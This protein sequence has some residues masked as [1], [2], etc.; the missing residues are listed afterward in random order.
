MWLPSQLGTSHAEQLKKLGLELDPERLAD[1]MG[2]PLGAVV[3]LGGCSASFVSADGLIITNHHCVTG[4][5]QHNSTPEHNLLEDGFLA[6]SPKAERTVGPTGRVFVTQAFTDVTERVRKGLEELTDDQARYLAVER[7]T[8]E[9]VAECE[10]AKPNVRCEV[11]S[12]FGNGQY[13]LVERLELKDVRL[14]YAPHRGIGDFGGEIDNWRWPR[15]GGDFA[16]YRVYVTKEGKPAPFSET[17]VPYHPSQHLKLATQPLREHDLVFVAGYPGRTSQLQTV[18]ELEEAVQWWYPRRIKQCEEYLAVLGRLSN[19]DRELKIKAAPLDQ[20]FNNSLTYTRGALEGLTKGG[21]SAKKRKQ[22]AD[23]E[24][25]VKGDPARERKYAAAFGKLQTI[26][27]ERARTRDE[28]AALDEVVRMSSLLGA[29]V[30][31]VRMAEE[32]PKPDAERKPDYQ[33]RNWEPIEQAQRSLEK[34]YARKLDKALLTLAAERALALSPNPSV[35][36]ALVGKGAVTH[37]AIAQA[38]DR[39]YAGTSLENTQLRVELLRRATVA[40]L[41]ASRDPLIRMALALR[42]LIKQRED[43]EE[44]RNGALLLWRPLYVA[45]LRERSSSP[46]APDANGTLRVTYGTVRGYAPSPGA[47]VYRPFTVVSEVVGKTTGKEPFDTPERLLAAVKAKKFG[48]YV[49]PALGEVPVD[50]LADLAITGGNS[51]S[52]TLNARGELVGLAF[53][54]NYEAMASDWLFMPDISRS[55]HVD[56]R[57]VLW[58]MDAVDGAAWLLEEM[59]IKPAF[60]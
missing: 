15:H 10:K 51:G 52:P 37:A 59:G 7:R 28:D 54:G 35:L 3:S 8:K 46:I 56:L 11:A 17:N 31:I 41:K 50:F 14:V 48:P 58:V 33:Q 20:G 45:A 6:D 57:Y 34:R 53:D 42:P 25:W 16:F 60:Q 29:A 55:I 43:R 36:E 4:A 26:F 30:T 1:P 9:I 21:A 38:V 40:Q 18:Y 22:W 39:T 49:D 44:A 19:G 5:L 32:R 27:E 24:T 2:Y 47:P 23:L 12:Y 13:L